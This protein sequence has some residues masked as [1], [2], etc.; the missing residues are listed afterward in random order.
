VKKALLLRLSSLGDVVLTSVLV[1]PL[2]KAGYEP[3]LLT[4]KPYGELFFWD[5]RLKVVQLSKEELLKEAPRFKDFELK[6]DL[7]KNLK[8][9]LFRL[10][11]GG[12]WRSYPKESLRRR[13]AVR[14]KAFRKPYGVT[15]AY[16]KALEGVAK[17]EDFRPFIKV[18]EE[19]AREYE[20]RFGAYAVLAPGARYEKKR[21]PR[22][23]EVRKLLEKEG[24]KVVVVGSA[25]ERELCKE[26]GGINLCGELSLREVLPLIKGARVFCG[27]DSGLLHCARAVRTKAL[28]VYGGTHPTLGFSLYPSEGKVLFK[29]LPCQPCH[30]H[31]KGKCKRGD[32]ACLDFP[33]EVVA[34]ELLSLARE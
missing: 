10:L 25:E 12:K 16:A 13:L 22:F 33:P 8:S 32:Y 1:E 9:Y 34:R 7:Q 19:K 28:Q 14:F 4:L 21:Y 24:L 11:S 15:E 30:P 29:D 27:N 26:V 18:P 2:L 3:H 31:G 23:S 20:R 17:V 5:D 6:V